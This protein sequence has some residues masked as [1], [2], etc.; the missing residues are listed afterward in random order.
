MLVL[1][2]RLCCILLLRYLMG[3]K[4]RLHLGTR[5]PWMNM[6]LSRREPELKLTPELTPPLL[7]G[8]FGST[9]MICISGRN[10]QF[11]CS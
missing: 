5:L 11:W 2:L 4:M 1:P 10:S 3:L 9:G 8:A 7:V 6:S